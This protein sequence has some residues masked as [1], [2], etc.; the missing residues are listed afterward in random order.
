MKR[1]DLVSLGIAVGG[2]AFLSTACERI[3]NAIEAPDARFEVSPSAGPMAVLG[4]E[5]FDD[6]NLSL[7]RNQSCRSCHD[8]GWGFTGPDSDANE[9]F[10]IYEGSVAGRF[11]DRRP[12]SSAYATLSPIFHF[13]L[14][15]GGLYVGG[16]FWDGRATGERLGN[17]A[18]EQA[19]GPF[20]NPLEQAL[21]DMACVV[22]LVSV[23]DYND[24]YEE[25]WGG[26]IFGIDFPS[27]MDALCR[28]ENSTI[29]LT[30]EDREQVG[31]EYDNIARS[32][33]A[34]EASHNAFTSRFDAARKGLYKLTSQEQLG[35]ALFQG[36]GRCAKCHP[37]SGQQPVFTDFTYDNLGVPANPENPFYAANPGFVDRGLGG[38]L[39]MTSEDGKFKVPTL[40]NVDLRPSP[41]DVKSYMH[42]GVFKSLEQVISFYNTRDALPTC[43]TG[44]PRDDW[45]ITCWPPAEVPQNVN[46]NELGNLGLTQEEEAAIIAF[47]KTL[48]DGYL[49]EAPS[50]HRRTGH[51]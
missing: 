23:A 38:F 20:L 24:L 3:P 15:R 32:I 41:T 50:R 42:N 31:A 11:G 19:Q 48:S 44:T 45:G 30:A 39:G 2:I 12:P 40:R 9:L 33:A 27:E 37:S 8:A 34:Y 10:G 1:V 17:P 22:Y 36:K 26:E 35:F 13:T 47:L 5:I 29:T 14:K 6:E 25:V 28:D 46:R 7:N 18:T 49:E 16:N 51:R 43:P 4:D 21:P